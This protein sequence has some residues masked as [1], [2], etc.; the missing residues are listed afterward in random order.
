MLYIL[1]ETYHVRIYIRGPQ[2]TVLSCGAILGRIPKCLFCIF[3][4][5][6]WNLNGFCQI[7]YIH[8]I[9][10]S[11]WHWLCARWSLTGTSAWLYRVNSRTGTLTMTWRAPSSSTATYLLF[12]AASLQ[13][14]AN[15]N[16]IRLVIY[17]ILA[18]F[19]FVM[20]HCNIVKSLSSSS[21]AFSLIVVGTLSFHSPLS[22]P[23]ASAIFTCFS[24]MCFLTT[25]LCLSFGLPIYQCP[26][27]SMFSVITTSSSVFLSTCPIH[28]SLT[29][30]IFSLTFATS[31]LDLISSFL[32]FSILFIPTIHLNILI[33]VLSS[34]FSSVP[35]SRLH[36][37][38]HH[39]QVNTWYLPHHFIH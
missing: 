27:T 36:T 3:L 38:E 7:K 13:R 22:P 29:S 24:S 30:L 34:K 20:D 15:N 1:I 17:I 16:S 39:Q 26:P 32:I 33:P 21:S 11:R 5:T 9:N 31:A 28:L 18:R 8:R 35:W 10:E 6:I 14:Y 2:Y 19:N 12:F 25:P 23:C 4:T 37:L